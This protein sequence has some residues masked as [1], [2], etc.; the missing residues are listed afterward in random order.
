M[1]QMIIAKLQKNPEKNF[2]NVLEMNYHQSMAFEQVGLSESPTGKCGVPQGLVME[3][4]FFM[5]F[6]TKVV[7]QKQSKVLFFPVWPKKKL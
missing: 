7:I 3:L 1:Q 5:L 2:L 6:F 4:F